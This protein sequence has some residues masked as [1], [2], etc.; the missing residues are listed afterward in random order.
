[1]RTN[2]FTNRKLSIVVKE[3]LT[4][5]Q[6]E[7]SIM[8]CQLSLEVCNQPQVHVI[9]DFMGNIEEKN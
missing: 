9:T 8:N 3:M 2:S 5:H 6:K 7:N 4:N 1:M